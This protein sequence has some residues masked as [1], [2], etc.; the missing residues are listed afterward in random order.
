MKVN[1]LAQLISDSAKLYSNRVAV[2][3]QDEEIT[4]KELLEKA[5][6][7]ANTLKEH[8]ANKEAIGL[9]G[10]KHMSSYVGVL[11]VLLSGCHYV[12]IN[13]KLSKDKIVSII[14][15]S[16]IKFLVGDIYNFSRIQKSLEDATCN[17]INKKIIP[18]ELTPSNDNWIDKHFLSAMKNSLNYDDLERSELTYVLYTS[19]STGQPKGVKVTHNNVI[20]F[21][22]NMKSIYPL[23]PGFRAS[24]MFDFSFDPSVSDM[25]FTWNLGGVLCVPSEDE[26]MVPYDFIRREKINY[27]NSVPSIIGFMQKM[28]FLSSGAFPSLEYSMFCGE[29]FTKRY[30]DAW[31][32]AAPNS[33]IENLYGPTEATIYTSRYLYPKEKV[34]NFFCNDI[35]PIGNPLPN[36]KIKVINDRLHKVN[37]N[38]IGE[39]VYKG[40]QITDGYLNDQE[41]TELVFVR[42]DWDKSGDI[43]YKSGD[44]GFY[45]KEGNLE[46]IGRKDNQIKLGG[47]R[48]EIG[49]IE[50][51]LS[52]FKHLHDVVV[53]ALKD[54]SQIT[55]DCIAFT[56]SEI[57]K[58]EQIR[59]RQESTQYL[60][61]VF[62]P[63]K[64][65]TI[66]E[67][68]RLPSGKIDRKALALE[69]LRL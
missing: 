61:K 25:F 47:R 28:G 3:I 50:A 30:A 69:A 59:I 15:D 39:L 2:K 22:E 41:K 16:N 23:R 54:E 35:L 63:K 66:G 53:V 33:T 14:N 5:T 64:I 13:P 56:T 20:A 37:A 31:M 1:S 17:K 24:Q 34:G 58:S 49:E 8:G 62:F 40:P 7:V 55:T 21:L 52:K 18:F 48:I 46:C 38:D 10:Q 4:Y 12:P 67:F 42:F 29:Q 26:M 57:S 6:Q 9:V 19:G 60:E 43:W 27:W 65:M 36:M 68:P 44:L 11:G 32:V 51:V 45:N